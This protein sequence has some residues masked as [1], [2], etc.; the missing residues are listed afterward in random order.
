MKR[1]QC[2]GLMTVLTRHQNRR[3]VAIRALCG[4]RTRRIARQIDQAPSAPSQQCRS[5]M[6]SYGDPRACTRQSSV[7]LT[8]SPMTEAQ[9]ITLASHMPTIAT[10]PMRRN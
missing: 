1:D 9:N 10:P 2:H 6:N 3:S 4:Q 5:D 7:Q 8:Q